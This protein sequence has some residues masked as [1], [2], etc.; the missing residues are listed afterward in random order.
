MRCLTLWMMAI[1]LMGRLAAQTISLAGLWRYE[2][3]RQD[4]GLQQGWQERTLS[5]RLYVPIDLAGQGIGDDITLDTPWTGSILDSAFYTHPDYALYRRAGNIKVPFWLQPGK[6]YCGPAWYQREVEIP[7]SWGS[8]RVALFIE[9]PHWE[10][11][12]WFDRQLVGVQN[13]LSTPHVYELPAAQP[14]KHTLTIR[15]DNRMVVPVGVNAHSVS[16]HTQ[17][18]WN[19]MVGRIELIR[20][21]AVW[22]E[23]LQVFPQVLSR[24][25]RVQGKIGSRSGASGCAPVTLT[26]NPGNLHHT[27]LAQWDAAGGTF[28]AEIPLGE[29]AVLWD[30]FHPFLY[31]LSASLTTNGQTAKTT[32]GLREITTA[33]TRFLINGRTTFIRGTLECAIFPKTGHPPTDIDSWRRI[34]STAKRFGLNTFRFHSW[35]PPEA[36]FVAADELG[37]YFQVE[38]SSWA[39]GLSDDYQLSLGMGTILDRWI[40]AEAE[41]ILHF[42]GNHPCFLFML[43]G[44]EPFGQKKDHYLR[45]WVIH[46]RALD[47][48]R[49]YSAA[50]GWPRLAENQFHVVPEPRI[51]KWGDGLKSRVN[52]QPPETV[53]DYRAFIDTVAQPVISHEIGQWCVYPNL[54]ERKKYSGYLKAKNFDIFYD[55]LKDHGLVKL[56]KRFLLAS[57]KLQAL[58]Y[59]EEIESALRTPGMAGFHLLQLHDFPGQGSALVGVLDPF[60]DEK[61]YITAAEFRRFCNSTVLLAR[62][63]KRIFT[64]QDTLKAEIQVAHFGSHPLPQMVCA[65]SLR[66]ARDQQVAQGRL[67]A[68]DI[69]VDGPVTLGSIA[70]PLHAVP[71]PAKY[72]LQLS[73]L[74]GAIENSWDVW[75][76][77][78]TISTHFP[79]DLLVTDR[80]DGA[81]INRL[82]QG[83]RALLFIPPQRVRSDKET[84]RIALGFSSIFWNTAWTNRQAPHTLGIL[85]DPGHPA[86]ADFP[87]EY[88]SNWQ[89]WYVV[90]RSGAMI[91]DGLPK[92]LQPI[93]RVID[94][95]F[96][97]CRLALVFEARV[98]KGRLLVCSADLLSEEAQDPVSRQLL[99]SLIKY[100]KSEKFHPRTPLTMKQVH[101]L[102]TA[103]D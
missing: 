81:L 17:G 31:H 84:G 13:A 53:T 52:A 25:V 65:W 16:D 63:A 8:G 33:G 76:Y 95:W 11:R 22:I 20:T 49:L 61:G 44:N 4:V 19:G 14:G 60:W 100:V 50:A 48:R 59:K 35:C 96:T 75:I 2:L 34:I 24:S 23:D 87:T 102:L 15:I 98:G 21:E 5:G 82:Q 46:F 56:A 62:L 27:T 64:V 26:I 66:N 97:A 79:D 12:V 83:G 71:A 72:T 54:A 68:C 29:T 57:G 69:P 51:Q 67:P 85:C 101:G 77:P 39:T 37:F 92:S 40:Y 28:T 74:D 89:W 42:Y 32:F 41:R 36:A 3:D 10:T 58:L 93:V 43:Y 103:D 80:V 45:E 91:L 78:A 94:D 55:R 1:V 47:C 88:H 7:E 99:S 18:N 90:S 73:A 38:C 30:E 70:I 9:R 6:Y 86:L